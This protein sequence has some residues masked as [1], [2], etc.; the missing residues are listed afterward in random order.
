MDSSPYLHTNTARENFYGMFSFWRSNYELEMKDTW[1][2]KNVNN[3]LENYSPYLKYKHCLLSEVNCAKKKNQKHKLFEN[4][5]QT[6][7][8]VLRSKTVYL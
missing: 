1:R 4:I 8:L 6:E 2:S 5:F 3:K 7:I